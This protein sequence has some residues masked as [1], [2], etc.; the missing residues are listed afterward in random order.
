MS[1]ISSSNVSPVGP[2]LALAPPVAVVPPEKVAAGKRL[3]VRIWCAFVFLMCAGM[4]GVGL[5]LHADASG[6]GTHQQMGFPP[7]GMLAMT[8]VP[9]PTCGCT[10][11]V[12]Y[13]AHGHVIMAFLTQPF[14]FAVGAL[15]VILLP[16]TVLGMVSGI[17][18]GPSMF[19]LGWYWR[20]W[21]YGGLALLLGA[22]VYK[23]ILVQMHIAL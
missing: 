21:T 1:D 3:E 2:E 16:L 19:V 6:S 23:I 7:C 15:A 9:C 8:G 5:K 17:W 18:K 11:A 20:Y 13:L 22:W 14:G 12:T 4:L 10:T